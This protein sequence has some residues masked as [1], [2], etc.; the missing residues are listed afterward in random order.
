M[1]LPRAVPLALLGLVVLLG[2]PSVATAS[3]LVGRPQ[4]GSSSVAFAVATS[5]EPIVVMNFVDQRLGRTRVCA[6]PNPSSISGIRLQYNC[7]P[8]IAPKTQACRRPTR[9]DGLPERITKGFAPRL[10]TRGDRTWL[11]QFWHRVGMGDFGGPVQRAPLELHLSTW[12]RDVAKVGVPARVNPAAARQ[13]SAATSLTQA[14]TPVL[15]GE[16]PFDGFPLLQVYPRWSKFSPGGYDGRLARRH[17]V[18]IFGAY[19]VGNVDVYG[20]ARRSGN[21][22]NEFGRNVYIDTFDADYGRGWRR[23]TGVLTQPKGGNW[24]YEFSPK[25]ASRGKLGISRSNRYRITIVGPGAL[26]DQRYEFRTPSFPLGNAQYNPRLDPWGVNFSEGQRAAILFQRT[27]IGPDYVTAAR[28][29]DCAKTIR[30]LNP[31]ITAVERVDAQTMRLSGSALR[32]PVA[33]TITP[34]GGDPIAVDP[35]AASTN[36]DGT[37]LTFPVPATTPGSGSVTVGTQWETATAPF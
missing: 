30:Q 25:P 35:A 13:P 22:T 4:G 31:K 8:S 24:C 3:S 20:P 1:R 36:R 16:A 27:L 19:R 7:P 9:R 15:G 14:T 12:T 37:R 10:C 32:D 29:T 17:Y 6:R 11:I 18:V 21:P 2:I 34:T 23:V 26:P 33:I 5:G 28:G